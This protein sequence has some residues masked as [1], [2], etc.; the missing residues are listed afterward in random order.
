ML[1]QGE[2][3]DSCSDVPCD[4]DT[5]PGRD[6]VTRRQKIVS[7]LCNGFRY[8][9][10]ICLTQ[11]WQSVNSSRDG[12]EGTIYATQSNTTKKGKFI[13]IAEAPIMKV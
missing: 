13:L 1:F 6:R 12:L 3:E 8:V 2:R 9:V 5:P 7:I 4:K 11:Q 10:M